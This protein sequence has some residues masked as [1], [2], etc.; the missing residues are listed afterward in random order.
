LLP[1]ARSVR[2]PGGELVMAGFYDGSGSAENDAKVIAWV[3]S[4]RAGKVVSWGRQPR[5]RPMWFVDVDR[6]GATER[7]VV[8]GQR[9]D[10]PM[11]FPLDHEMRFQRVLEEQG[12]PVPKVYG[13]LDDPIAYALE[14]VPGRPDFAGVA[15]EDRDTIVDEYLHALADVHALPIE[16]FIEA[17]IIRGKSPDDAGY[18]GT[19]QFE[20][21]YRQ[22]KVRPNPL[23]EFV[24]GWLKRHPL[25]ES[26]RETPVV[27][28]SGQFHHDGKHF[29]SLIDVELG[30]LGDP[31][32]DLAGWRM[33]ETVIP[34]GDFGQIY[35][36]YAEISGRPVDMAA[37][38]W[39]HLFFTLTNQLGFEG[40]LARPVLDTDY[41][42]YAH[43]VSE[44]NLHAIETMAEYLGLEL[45]DVEIPQPTTSPVSGPHEHLSRSL[46]SIKVDDAYIK[47]QVRIA[48]R[49]ARHLERFD[50][51]GAEVVDQDRADLSALTG[52][53][54]VGWD[55]CEELLEKFVLAD[56][57]THDVELVV[58]FNRR[59][60]R[61]KA[62]MGPEGSAMAAHHVMQPLGRSLL[63]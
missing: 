61:Y 40:P 34:F 50:Q 37:I 42:T 10:V 21:V 57:G 3:E 60:R 45:E 4:L 59:W 26:D 39:H 1:N 47:Y 9:A 55:E 53:A 12:M 54:P 44:T 16:P 49:L 30:H 38:Q 2:A 18:V 8:R 23:M 33:R 31:M 46:R 58:L 56:D 14:A 48:F 36:R 62:L 28:D 7:I 25:P 43:W 13:W 51:I 19:R 22:M 11:S 29:G 6:D 24:L 35:D 17:D 52:R 5:W 63:G 27:W 41:M 20:R 32:M 15:A